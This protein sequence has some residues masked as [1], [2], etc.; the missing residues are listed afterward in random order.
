[1]A[2]AELDVVT[3]AFSFTG[4]YIA[5]RLLALGRQ[6]KTLTGHPGREHPFGNAVTAVPFQFEEPEALHDGL[7]GADTL[8]NTYW[9]RFEHGQTTFA[10][11][12]A[13]TAALLAAARQAGV[14]RV[15]H[16]SVAHAD[17][18]SPYPY[19]RAKGEAERL[20]R[21]SGLSYA[22]LRPT[23]LFGT[24]G[25][26]FNNIAYMLRRFPAFAIPG[27]GDYRLQP[28]YVDDLAELA[29][30][31]GHEKR[32]LVLDAAGP[33]TFTFDELV[34]RMAKQVGSHARLLHMNPERALKLIRMVG[35]LV[36]DVVLTREEI[37]GL[38]EDMLA[39]PGAPAG[40]TLFS[41][42]LGQNAATLGSSYF[43]EMVRH[44]K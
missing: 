41:S 2:K 27:K 33:E 5:R 10:K 22:I 24:E 23:V 31:A 40:H 6:V 28:I 43:S 38:M 36:G 8:Y 18:A 37:D 29:V 30:T 9:V 14:R 39:V 17:E 20:V 11:A 42:W 26:L 16:I 1:M 21:E 3:G 7:A 13:H 19:F 32:S 15:V 25:I 35:G 34:R 44:Y 12:V 4:K